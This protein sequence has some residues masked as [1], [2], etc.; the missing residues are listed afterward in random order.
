MHSIHGTLT[1]MDTVLSSMSWRD[2][3]GGLL[4]TQN[5]IVKRLIS[6]TPSPHFWKTIQTWKSK[7]RPYFYSLALN[8]KS[9][10]PPIPLTK[11][12]TPTMI[13]WHSLSTVSCDLT[14]ITPCIHLNIQYAEEAIFM[15]A[16]QCKTRFP[17]WCTLS[18]ASQ[19]LPTLLIQS[20]DLFWPEW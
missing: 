19:L 5:W 8:C 16:L 6:L 17:D 11:L 7:W 13:S 14:H 4:C 12:Y 20:R 15:L 2:R 10:P 9:S 1:V 18:Y 3:S